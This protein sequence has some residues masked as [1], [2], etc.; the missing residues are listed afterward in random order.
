[1]GEYTPNST[2]FGSMSTSLSSFGCFLN[3]SEEM[4]AFRPTDL[5]C[6]VAPATSRWGIFVKSTIN[7]SFV[8]VLPNASGSSMS[9][10]WNFLEFSMLSIETIFGFLFGTSI[11]MV[12][13]PG[14]GAMIRVERAARLS[15]MSSSRVF[16]LEMR[17]PG[18]GVIS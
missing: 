13:L 11:P 7:T 9:D 18:A 8:I 14:I 17:T 5:P 12:P 3:K 6:P 16:I 15:A 1:M 10:S 4:M 2:F